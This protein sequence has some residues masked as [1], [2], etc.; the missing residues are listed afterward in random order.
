VYAFLFHFAPF[1]GAQR[2][3]QAMLCSAA[4]VLPYIA[5]YFS[6]RVA[7][8][9]ISRVVVGCSAIIAAAVGSFVY[10]YSFGHNDGEYELVYFA[11]PLV[12][13]PFVVAAVVITLW[14]RKLARG[15]NAAA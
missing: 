13:L 9:R 6:A 5:L 10:S 8:D 4:V 3:G 1:A 11:V 14:R 12:Q 15:K 7:F 2:A